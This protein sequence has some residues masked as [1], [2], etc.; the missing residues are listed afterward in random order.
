MSEQVTAGGSGVVV[1]TINYRLVRR[2][3]RRGLPLPRAACAVFKKSAA[4][5]SSSALLRAVWRSEPRSELLQM[6]TEF[7][8]AR[9]GWERCGA[10]SP[11]LIQRRRPKLPGHHGLL[12]RGGP[13]RARR[14]GR[15]AQ[16]GATLSFWT[17]MAAV[18]ARSSCGSLRKDSQRQPAAVWSGGA[19]PGAGSTGNY[20]LQDQRMALQWVQ[21]RIRPTRRLQLPAPPPRKRLALSIQAPR[22]SS[23][24]LQ[25]HRT[26]RRTTSRRSAGTPRTC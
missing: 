26:P 17:S 11:G 18:A 15:L 10:A 2:R 1:V 21:V 24:C 19:R 4:A 3:P 20:G 6:R 7:R 16:P 22:T 9:R 12:G 25:T 8:A 13:A 14:G 5:G 23:G